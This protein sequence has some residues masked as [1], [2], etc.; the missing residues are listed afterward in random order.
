M[1]NCVNLTQGNISALLLK[2]LLLLLGSV[3][4]PRSGA[5]WGSWDV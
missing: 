3:L 4:E 1:V 2:N 5:G